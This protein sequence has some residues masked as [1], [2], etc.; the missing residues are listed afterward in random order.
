M[1]STTMITGGVS[2]ISGFI[3]KFMAQKNEIAAAERKHTMDM[4]SK[5]SNNEVL[6][7]DKEIQLMQAKAKFEKVVS[8]TDPHR[9]ATRRFIVYAVITSFVLVAY[10]L[11]LQPDIVWF[12]IYD[13]KETSGG[14][15]G[16][17]A[18][19]QNVKTVITSSGI[20]LT[21]FAVMS[22]TMIAIVS[23]YFGGSL[24]KFR[25]PYASK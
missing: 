13:T 11:A 8:K 14:F 9:S 2:A 1:I 25:N 12:E 21:W 20:P 3:F 15:L 18:T 5:Q 7:I 19:V 4:L 10:F 22:E 23:F 17:G 24:A 6:K 16:I